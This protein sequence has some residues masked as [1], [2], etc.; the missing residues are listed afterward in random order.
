MI[1]MVNFKLHNCYVLYQDYHSSTTEYV[2]GDWFGEVREVDFKQ[3]PHDVCCVIY[4]SYI[5]LINR[6]CVCTCIA[7]IH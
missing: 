4:Q 3:K 7:L 6:E 2:S 5:H 1:S